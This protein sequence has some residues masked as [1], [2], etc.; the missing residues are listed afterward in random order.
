MTL[1][2]RRSPPPRTW[3][4]T[5]SDNEL[6]LFDYLA[7]MSAVYLGLLSSCAYRANFNCGYTH[8][9]SNGQLLRTINRLARQQLIAI[10]TDHYDGDPPEEP[11]SWVIELTPAGGELWEQERL[12]RWSTF[13]TQTMGWSSCIDELITFASPSRA[14]LQDFIRVRTEAGFWQLRERD[15]RWERQRDFRLLGWK[16]F[17]EAWT[18][19]FREKQCFRRCRNWKYLEEHR[20]WWRSI[21]DTPP[22]PRD[23]E[24]LDEEF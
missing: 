10:H 8:S 19:S 13:V 2:S 11:W 7:M 16:R 17:P 3:R 23:A 1:D 5:L 24:D 4:T 14:T 21:T 9:L 12:P 20:T 6:L 22:P 18:A 15:I